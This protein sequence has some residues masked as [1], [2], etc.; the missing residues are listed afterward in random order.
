MVLIVSRGLAILPVPEVGTRRMAIEYYLA[1][2]AW[3]AKIRLQLPTEQSIRSLYGD[4]AKLMYFVIPVK[5]KG[6]ILLK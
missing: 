2:S 1:F 5:L 6:L 4:F 3:P